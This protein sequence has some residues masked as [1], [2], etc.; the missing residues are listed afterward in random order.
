MS[1][2]LRGLPRGRRPSRSALALR[3][4]GIAVLCGVAFAYIHPIR[5]YQ[6]ARDDVDTR[7]A[8]LAALIQKRDKLERELEFA[9]TEAFIEREARTHGL[10]RKGE[11]LFLVQGIERWQRNQ[12][13]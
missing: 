1:P 13:R 11:T 7:K 6:D 9:T 8:Q 12:R 4:F 3:W 2:T 5:S 10:V